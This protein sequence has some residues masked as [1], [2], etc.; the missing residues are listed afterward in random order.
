M[1]KKKKKSKDKTKKKKSK[2][3]LG[4]PLVRLL[5]KA[6][7]LVL[8]LA[9]AAVLWNPELVPD[10]AQRE[11]VKAMRDIAL[12]LTQD[13]QGRVEEYAQPLSQIHQMTQSIPKG[14]VLGDQEV[15]VEDVV[16]TVAG[17]L[18]KLPVEQ[19]QQFR[20]TLCADLV[21]TVAACLAE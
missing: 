2:G 4:N 8:L 1:G 15:Y 5:G 6:L 20:A 18:E 21:A 12:S 11:K 14:V 3:I 13:G 10:E 17:E 9:S 7:V 19:F 16:M